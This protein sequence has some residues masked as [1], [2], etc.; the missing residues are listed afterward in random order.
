MIILRKMNDK[1]FENFKAYSIKD[2]ASD[3]LKERDIS[4]EEAMN[5]AAEEFND[6]LPDGLNTENCFPMVIEDPGN[7]KDVGRIWYGYEDNGGVRQ[8]FL[9]DLLIDEDERRKGYAAKALAEME[10]KAREDGCGISSLYVWE[11]NAPAYDLYVKCGYEPA[12]SGPDGIYMKKELSR[13]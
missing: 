8:V 3:M 6:I 1:E 10:R 9:F 13:G 2:Y 4:E 12:D 11:H 5:S 7:R